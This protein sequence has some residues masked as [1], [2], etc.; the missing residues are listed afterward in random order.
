MSD[1]PAILGGAPLRAAEPDWPIRDPA[2]DAAFAELAAGGGWGKY[3][4]DHGERLRETL[5]DRHGGG[6]VHLCSGGT[7]AVE[8]AL[9]GVGV[10]PGDEVVLSAYDFSANFANVLSLDARPVLV[11]CRADDAQLD[12]SL[13]A[14]ALTDRTRAVLTSH[15]H[16]GTVDMPALRELCDDRGVAL[17]ED[18]CQMPLAGVHG[19]TAGTWGHVGVL[20]FGGSKTLSAGRGGAVVTADP[21]LKQRIALHTFRGNDVSP[22]SEM[23]AAVLLPQIQRFD[24]R[25]QTRSRSVAKL[26]GWFADVDGLTMFAPGTGS[27]DYY[28]VG[29][30]YDPAAFGGLSRDRFCEAVHAEGVT[31][32]PSFA[33]LHTTHS[34]R[35]FDAAGDLPN[36]TRAGESVVVLHHPVL[37]EDARSLRQVVEAVERVRAHATA[38]CEDRV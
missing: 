3:L 1:R 2:V 36:A 29:F 16:G 14:E 4:G 18:V 30:F 37:L 38:I 10:R 22:L 15:L 8:L 32:S 33:S 7:A 23:Q 9:R 11:D 19:R 13:V 25:H 35:R 5:R 17:I 31:L 28:K 6:F 21:L 24:E 12:V 27:P 34:R 20:S 26:R